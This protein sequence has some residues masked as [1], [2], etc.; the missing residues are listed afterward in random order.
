MILLRRDPRWT[1]VSLPVDQ[2][3]PPRSGPH[4]ARQG[5]GRQWFA[6]SSTSGTDRVGGNHWARA[7]EDGLEDPL[8]LGHPG[9]SRRQAT[10]RAKSRPYPG[11]N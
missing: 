6:S 7:Y 8:R 10:H 5:V 9:E 2:L 1:L 3:I 4:Y 11:E